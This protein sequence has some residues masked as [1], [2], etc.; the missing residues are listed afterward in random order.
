[1]NYINQLNNFFEVKMVNPISP[2]AQCLYINLFFINNKC[3]WKERFTVSNT[4]IS[5]LTGID[6]RTLDRVRNELIQKGYI[7]YKKGTGNQAG[8]YLIV[9]FDT[10]TDTQTDTQVGTQMSHNSAHN[11]S[12]L[13]KQKLN[14]T[15]NKNRREFIAPSLEEVQNYVQEKNLKVDAN[16]FYNY[17]TEGNW[18]DSKG[19]EVKNWKQKI[20]TWNG[21]SANNT[22]IKPQNA[23]KE[24]TQFGDLDKF[25]AN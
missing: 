18:I 20:L 21:Y 7:E 14:K 6:R 3:G 8:T 17:F 1:M 5:A 23:M 9:Q 19:N 15:K 12:T 2:N 22:E 4:M 25:Y 16:K 10:Q 13:N 24:D 11:M